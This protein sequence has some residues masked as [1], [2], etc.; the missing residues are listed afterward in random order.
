M[1]EYITPNF[2]V[3]IYDIKEIITA[4]APDVE[5]GKDDPNG[6]DDDWFG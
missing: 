4:S 6:N 2:D 3:T 5:F 1:K